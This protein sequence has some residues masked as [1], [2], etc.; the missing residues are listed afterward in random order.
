[1]ADVS[2]VIC[3]YNSAT[4]IEKTLWHLA[5][6][7]TKGIDWEIV[8]V[9]NAS[10]D[11]TVEIATSYWTSLGAKQPL[12]I[13][14]E[15]Q[16]GLSHARET[17]VAAAS[18]PCII[19]CDDDNW[20]TEN[21]IQAAHTSFCS[22]DESTGILGAW[23]EGEYEVPPG[24]FVSSMHGALSIGTPQPVRGEFLQVNGAG[25]VIRKSCFERAQS[26]GASL[27]LDRTG[28]L[29]VSGGDTELCYRAA[30]AGYRVA[31]GRELSFIHFM[32][33][34][35][36]TRRY[37]LRLC[38]GTVSPLVV[39]AQYDSVY[40]GNTSFNLFRRR[41]ATC[42]IKRVLYCFPRMVL[43]RHRFYNTVFFL[44]SCKLLALIF[45]QRGYF[46]QTFTS[47]VKIKQQLAAA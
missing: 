2:V 42:L 36:L 43:G 47:I 44:Q 30:Y 10:T 3:C 26:V 22:Y 18:A 5:R 45:I 33:A 21:Y 34:G 6:Q 11:R 4:R 29:L 9:D 23:C 1:M 7:I 13:V 38:L 12:R 28:R 35:R 8:L 19:F 46:A 14:T 17:G 32:P 24:D 39:L 15:S 41:Y 25:M 40:Q 37:L 31:F 20:L 16:P 27:L